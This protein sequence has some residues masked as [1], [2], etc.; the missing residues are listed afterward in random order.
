MRSI[1]NVTVDGNRYITSV[2]INKN[3][4]IIRVKSL[5]KDNV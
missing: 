1:Y 3:N 5:Y 4:N 2:F